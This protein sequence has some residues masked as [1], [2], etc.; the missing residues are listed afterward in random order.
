MTENKTRVVVIGGGYAGV[1]AANRLSQRPELTIALI[2]PRPRFVERI[3]LHQLVAGNDD[4]TEGYEDLLATGIRLV[5]D[6]ATRI[7]AADR[8]IELASGANL[9]Y[10]YL[11]YAVGS[12]GGVPDGVPGA[13]EF[14]YPTLVGDR[15]GPSLAASG[16]KS[17]TKALR[18]LGV[19][20]VDG[21]KVAA[22]SA[23][24]V[25]LSDGRALPSAATVWTAGFGVPGLA[26]ASGLSTDALG[27]LRTH[28][29]LISVD[30]E[31]IIAA[32]DAASPSD[33]PL[34]MSCQAALPLGAQAADTV[35]ALLAGD[36]P[37]P[38]RQA[39]TG[40]CISLGRMAGT[41]QVSHADDSPRRAYLGGRTAAFVKEQVCRFTVSTLSKEAAKPG[42]AFWFKSDWRADKLAAAVP[43]VPVHD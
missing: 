30:D 2:N 21:V 23:D 20:I 27:R 18:K 9:P 42:S 4:A 3:R 31:R 28:E 13:A 39:F 38:I 12:T 22:L 14:A 25:R 34:R 10:D 15:V 32:G 29:T 17:V 37:T 36:T 35:L 26:A 40:Q 16:R 5:V 7:D 6:V 19:S 8:Q 24:A 33:L 41:V 43:G 1:L 11:I